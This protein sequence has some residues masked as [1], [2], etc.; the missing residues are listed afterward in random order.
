MID[1]PVI[2]ATQEVEVGGSLTKASLGK[3]E[4]PY[5]KNKLNKRAGDMA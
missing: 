5:L 4:R 3:S 2:P 1:A